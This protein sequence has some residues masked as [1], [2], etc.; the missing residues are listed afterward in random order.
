MTRTKLWVCLC[1]GA[2]LWQLFAGRHWETA[3][4]ASFFMALAMLASW[5]RNLMWE[6]WEL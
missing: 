2:A 1:A 5:V 6:D 3:V 4:E